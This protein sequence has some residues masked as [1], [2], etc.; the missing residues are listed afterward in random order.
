MVLPLKRK[1]NMASR[2][3]H[4]GSPSS[5]QTTTDILQSQAESKG[6]QAIAADI[7]IRK[8]KM[9]PSNTMTIYE[10]VSNKNCDVIKFDDHPQSFY[11]IMKHYTPNLNFIPDDVKHRELQQNLFAFIMR[12]MKYTK[13]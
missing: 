2:S 1:K 13:V 10:V 9:T 7:F 6:K 12:N 8:K 4:V 3:P 5:T 11:K